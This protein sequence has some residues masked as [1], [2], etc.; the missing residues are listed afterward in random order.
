MHRYLPGFAITFSLGAGLLAQPSGP[1]KP[2]VKTPGIKIPIERLKPDA[3]FEVPGAP[4]WIAVDEAVWISNAPKDTVARLDPKTNTVAATIAV[5]K[6]PCS[7]I[8]AGF[9]S[10][11]VPNCADKTLARIDAKTGAVTTTIPVT[12]G[13]SEG[14]IVAG[15]GSIWLVTDK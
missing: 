15:A 11:W 3:V 8:A 10:I 6:R 14:S 13:S 1:P 7:G 2:G 9:G 12:I 5:G 4:D